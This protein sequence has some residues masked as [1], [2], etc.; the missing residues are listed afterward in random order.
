[1]STY[2]QLHGIARNAAHA[3]AT[4]VEHFAFLAWTHSV[5]LIQVNLLT[6]EI[7]PDSFRSIRNQNLVST[8]MRR[9]PGWLE[10]AKVPPGSVTDAQLR[11]EVQ[12]DAYSRTTDHLVVRVEV[13][14]HDDRGREH[15]G[16]VEAHARPVA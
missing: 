14:L 5:S 9:L 8:I 6:G 3:F 7:W 11:V 1:V 16:Q 4:S 13:C 12:L 2:R 10:A 15:H